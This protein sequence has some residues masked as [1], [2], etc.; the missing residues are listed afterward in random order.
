MSISVESINKFQKG[1]LAENLGIE[2]TVAE[3]GYI[4]AKMPVDHR[5]IQP[6]KLLHGGATAALA[7]SMGSM[8]SYMLIDADKQAIVGLELN[9]N[10]LRAA[11]SGFVHAK[12]KAI[13]Q[14]RKTH[15]WQIE[16][17]NEAEKLVSSSRLT[18]MVI[19]QEK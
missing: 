13:H 9:I 17:Y 14:G 15:V 2:F 6:L 1:T 4:E 10:H 8:G 12:A 7:E 11:K 3:L 19:D 18:V 16:I 5:T